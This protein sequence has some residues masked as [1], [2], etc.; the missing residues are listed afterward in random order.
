MGYHA[1]FTVALVDVASDA[2][3]EDCACPCGGETFEV[4][5]GFAL[6]DGGDVKWVS[7]GLRCTIDGTLGVYADWKIDYSPT[8]ALFDRV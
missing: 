8:T 5:V 1:A 6:R 3:P 2:E 7:V 4:A